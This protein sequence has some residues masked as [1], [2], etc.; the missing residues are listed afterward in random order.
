[1]PYR[2]LI[3]LEKGILNPSLI[4]IIIFYKQDVLAS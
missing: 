2:L 1:M 3:T 4:I